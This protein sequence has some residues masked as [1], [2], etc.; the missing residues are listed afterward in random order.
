MKHKILHCV[1]N[2]K[3]GF[4]GLRP[5]KRQIKECNVISALYI[6][7]LCILIYYHCFRCKATLVC[8]DFPSLAAKNNLVILPT[9]FRTPSLIMQWNIS[10]FLCRIGCHRYNPVIQN[11]SNAPGN[12]VSFQPA[13]YSKRSGVYNIVYKGN[14]FLFIILSPVP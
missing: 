7:E 2:G 5:L 6:D 11:A 3:T 14:R 12:W 13:I 1:Q 4:F 8:Y 10:D 9:T